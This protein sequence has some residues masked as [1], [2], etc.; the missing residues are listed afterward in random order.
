[1]ACNENVI[2]NI[3]NEITRNCQAQNVTVDAEFVIFLIELLLLNPKYGK[4]FSKVINRDTLQYFVEECGSK[5]IRSENSINT[6]KMQFIV[7]KN[8]DKL[9]VL[10]SKHLESIDTC[11]R[12][13]VSEILEEEPTYE[14]DNELK[15]MFRKIS[16]YII[17][18][19]GLGNPSNIH[20]L[21]EGMAALESVFSLEDLNG[22]IELPKAEKMAHLRHL[23]EIVSGVRLFNRDCK[24]GGEGIPDL[25]FNL[26]DAGKACL[27]SLSNSLITVMQRVNT[28]TTA[29]EDTIVIEDETGNV[30]FDLKR[31]ADLTVNDVKEVI[32]LLLFYRQYEVFTRRLLSDVQTLVS[33]AKHHVEKVRHVLDDIHAAVKYKSA[34]PVTTVFPLFCNLWQVWRSMQNTMYLI[35]TVNRLISNLASIQDLMKIPQS[36]VDKMLAGR[37]VITDQD[38][39][40]NRISLVER[41][42]MANLEN[43]IPYSDPDIFCSG[44]EKSAQFLGFCAVCLTVGA[45][46]PGNMKVGYIKN[47]GKRYSFCNIKMATRFAK[48]PDRYINEVLDFARNNPHVIHLLNI[49]EDVRQVKDLDVLVVKYVPKICVM[50]KDVQTEPHPIDEYI[51]KDYTWDLWEWKRRACKW[52]SIVNCRT[53]STQTIYSHLRSEIQ[54][55]TAEPRDKCQQTKKE[56]GMN[57][58]PRNVFLWGLR[59]Q[60]GDGQ[61]A[62]DLIVPHNEKLGGRPVDYCTWPC[63]SMPSTEYREVQEQDYNDEEDFELAIHSKLG[64]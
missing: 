31:T 44:R 12:P 2:K 5:L 18:S 26:V 38:R 62:M 60:I 58:V 6:L 14:D 17:L 53:H 36:I 45:L 59:G 3:A 13:L 28:L 27:A 30:G 50:E 10:I 49:I 61:H 33:S 46:N 29:L 8:Y 43:Y 54:C 21:K 37:S 20:N 25:P 57:T 1:M 51:E 19:S 48:N 24:K 32:E 42:S 4:L 63:T 40:S 7:Q 11:L 41:L 56:T 9:P 39:I 47:R 16:I 34:V 55:Q 22:F 52:A 23:M 35:S 15:K 64:F